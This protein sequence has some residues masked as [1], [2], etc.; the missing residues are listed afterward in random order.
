MGLG[1]VFDRNRNRHL[2][3]NLPCRCGHDDDASVRQSRPEAV[4][5]SEHRCILF[6]DGLGLV[7]TKP[8]LT[9]QAP[10]RH[11]AFGAFAVHRS[12]SGY[13]LWTPRCA[14]SAIRRHSIT[15]SFTKGPSRGPAT[16]ERMNHSMFSARCVPQLDR[17]FRQQMSAPGPGRS[18]CLC[19]QLPPQLHRHPFRYRGFGPPLRGVENCLAVR[20]HGVKPPTQRFVSGDVVLRLTPLSPSVKTAELHIAHGYRFTSS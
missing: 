11:D 9:A 3:S 14:V 15:Q 8:K 5:H 4:G 18:P 12:I 1:L 2:A 19:Y 16:D 13:G 6:G 20:L 10:S 7:N 17:A